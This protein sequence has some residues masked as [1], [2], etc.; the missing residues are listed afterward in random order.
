MRGPLPAKT[1]STENER[2]ELEGGVK[3]RRRSRMPGSQPIWHQTPPRARR[4]RT[5]GV[6]VRRYDVV[7]RVVLCVPESSG[8]QQRVVC[9]FTGAPEPHA[10]RCQ[11]VGSVVQLASR[12]LRGTGVAESAAAAPGATVDCRGVAVGTCFVAIK[13]V[14]YSEKISAGITP[15]TN[16]FYMYYFALTGLHLAHVVIG[17]VVLTVLSRLAKAEPSSTH[18]AFFES[19]ACFWHMVDLLWLVIF[20]LIFLVR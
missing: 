12:R 9:L 5:L 4:G 2:A 20:P 15:G 10:G 6:A 18:I 17:L 19:G 1:V 16:D 3:H 8:P 14:E 13:S 11:Y 7:H